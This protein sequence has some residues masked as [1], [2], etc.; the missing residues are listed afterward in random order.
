MG[1]SVNDASL[2][3]G[4]LNVDGK[5]LK[6]SASSYYSEVPDPALLEKFFVHF[7]TRDCD[8]IADLTDGACTTITPDMIPLADDDKALGD[9]DQHGK[10]G[11]RCRETQMPPPAPAPCFIPPS[12]AWRCG[13]TSRPSP[14]TVAVPTPSCNSRRTP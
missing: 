1:L 13:P 9:P 2:L 6:G 4:A 12:S 11:I 7:F 10:F 14:S 5:K 8:A 3:K